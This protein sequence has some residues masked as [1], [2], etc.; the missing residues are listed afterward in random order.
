M[1]TIVQLTQLERDEFLYFKLLGSRSYKRHY[2]EI[3]FTVPLFLLLTYE[4][5]DH[6]HT[7]LGKLILSLL[8]M[9]WLIK[10]CD[11]FWQSK[12]HC[13]IENRRITSPLSEE[14]YSFQFDPK[15]QS[16]SMNE[17]EIQ[18]CTNIHCLQSGMILTFNQQMILIPWRIF[19]SEKCKGQ[20]V[21][22][23]MK[24]KS[25]GFSYSHKE[26]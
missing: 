2:F 22:S 4:C 1:K 5:F 26:A 24:I 25:R 18:S 3:C 23:C 10:G 21:R 14:A 17:T 6:L 15:T 19:E 7:P 8:S 13:F 20:F 16:I 12:I 11:W 9:V